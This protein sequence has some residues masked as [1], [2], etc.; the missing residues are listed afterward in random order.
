MDYY[1]LV[2][3]P[4][5]FDASKS[6][7]CDH[8]PC[9][10]FVW[11]FG[12]GSPKETTKG[13]MTQH[14]YA[15]PGVYPVE[16]EVTDKYGKTGKA[17]CTQ[18]IIDPKDPD[19]IG[20]P[21]AQLTSDPT[22]SKVGQVVYFDASKSHD[23]QKKP[24]EHYVFD[25]GDGTK[26]LHS[27]VPKVTHPYAKRGA[28]PVTV[29]VTDKYGQKAKAGLQ[30][31][32]ID[33][34]MQDPGDPYAHLK[35]TPSEA[36]TKEP[37]EFDG[38]KSMDCD[39]EPVKKYVFD[40]G[41]GSKPVT[42]FKP[43]VHH[44][45]AKGGTYPV[46][47][48]VTDKYG[49][50][51]EAMISQ[52]VK[53]P[54]NPTKKG[55]PS[56]ALKSTPPLADIDEPVTFDASDSHDYL[57]E[58]CELFVWD[59]G[60]GSPKKTSTTPIV[61]HPYK[62][63]GTYPVTVKVTDK[64]GQSAPAKI[65]QRVQAPPEYVTKDQAE[66][67]DD[68]YVT[69]SSTPTKA[70]INQPVTF[71]ASP[72]KDMD[73]E[74]LKKFIW[75]FGDG[76]P[77]KETPGP[78]VKHPYKESGTYPVKVIGVDKYGRKGDAKLNQ[79]VVDPKNPNEPL[80]PY[81]H[82]KSDPPI[83]E[84]KQPVKFDASKSHD[85]FN[86]PCVQFVW[87]FGDGSPKVTTPG[88][89]TTHP[90]ENP[91]T[92]P[93]KV[94]VTD[95]NGLSAQAGLNQK[96]IQK[97]P[98]E[99]DP[100][101]AV[102]STPPEAKPKEPVRFDA[103]KSHD[104]DG[105][106][107]KTFKWD[108][109]DG[110]P[111]VTTTTPITNHAY[112][113]PGT[114]PVKVT[115][116]DKYNRQGDA[117]LQQKVIDPKNPTKKGPPYA[118][119]K[120][121]PPEAAINQPVLFDA[122][123]SHDF[124]GE[125]CVKYVWDFGDGSPKKTTEEPEVTHPYKKAGVYPVT[126]EVTDKY[127]QKGKAGVN[128]RVRAP[129]PEDP[130]AAL[131]STP[132]EAKPKE[133]VKFD[134]SRSIDCDGDPCKQF[135][136]DFGDKSPPVIS[137]TPVVNH[138]YDEPGT[139][140]VTVTV[141]DKHGNRANASLQQKVIDPLDP[142]YANNNEPTKDPYVTVSSTPTKAK[143]NEPVTFDASPSHD[144]DKDPLKKFIWD[145][146]DGSP[147]KTTTGPITKHPYKK[148]GTYPVTVTGVDKYGRKGNAKLNQLVVDP[149]NP[150]K[151][152][153]PYAAVTSDPPEAK[154]DE[155]VK[156]DASKSHDFEKK[157]CVKFVWDFGDKSPKVTTKE[158]YT[159]HP[160]KAPGKYPV[161]VQ[162]T[163]KYN[164]TA[165]AGLDQRVVDPMGFYSVPSNEPLKDPTVTVSSTPS[166]AKV[167]EPVTFDASPSHDMDGEPL[168]K[169]IWDFGDGSPK[170]TT[171]EPIV[172]HPYKKPGSYPV[173]VTGIDKYGQ[174]GNAKLT[175]QVIDPKN[176]KKKLPPYAAITSDPP[177]SKVDEP[178]KF[179]A[180]K[181]H[182]FEKKPCKKFV[183]DFGDGSPKVTTTEPYTTHP[184]K[185][186]GKYPVTV[187]VT[188]RF[189]QKA[190]AGL[191]QRVV[192]P[193]EFYNIPSNDPT[194]DPYV[195]VSSTPPTAKPKEPVVFDASKSHDMDGDPC[196][197][198]TWDF[199]DGSPLVH[200]PK[201]VVTHA[202]DNPGSYP[203]KVTAYDKYNRKGDASLT[204]KVID[205]KNPKK[206][207]PP[208]AA[209]T[210]DPPVADIKEPV[211]FDASESK[212]FED[213]PCVK[214]VWDFGD[215]S[216]K[217]ITK[218]PTTKHP[219]EKAG[220]YPVT[221]E[222][223]DKHNQ[224]AKAGLTQKVAPGGARNE[225]KLP[226]ED[227][228]VAVSSTPPE[229]KVKEPVTFDASK[230]HDMD[231]DPLKKYLW[232]FGDG[233]PK[234]ETTGPV[235]KHAYDKPGTYP[236]TV[237]GTDKYNR[238]G[239]AKLSQV[240]KD[241]KGGPQPPYAAI[242]STPPDAQENE[243]VLFDASKSK[244]YQGNPVVSYEWD[245]GDG[246][247]KKTSKEPRIKHPYKKAG[248]YP[249][250][251][252]VTDKNGLKADA[253][254]D[255]RVV[256]KPVKNSKVKP[257]E[258]PF[259]TVSSTPTQAKV[260]EPVTFDASPSHDMDDDPLEKFIWD[261]GDG[262]P[263]KTTKEPIV[264]HPYKKP[265]TYPVT[266]TGI[267]KY[268]RKGD[269]KLN[270]LVIDPKNPK[271]VLPPY[272]ALESTPQDAEEKEPVT[273]DASKSHDF[274]KKPVVKYVWDFGDG[275]P[276][277]TTKTPL[278]K[279]PYEKAGTYPVTVTVTD[280]HNQ[281]A[282]ASINQRVVPPGSRN[283]ISHPTE[284]P[285]VT[286]S[287]TPT[288][289]KINQPVKFDA[290]PSH[291]MDGDPL[292]KFVWDFGDGSPKKTTTGPTTT[293]PYKKPGTYPVTVVGTD[294]YNRK[295][296]AKLNQQVIDPK[297]PKD[298]LP[299][300]AA[301]TS[302]PPTSKVGQ[303]VQF[304]ASKS[305]DG[306]KKP[307][308]KFVWDFGDGSPKQI[309]KGPKTKHP[310]EHEGTYPVSV[311]VT[312]KLGQE[313][314]AGLN[315][316]VI[317]EME[318]K[319]PMKGK[320][321][322]DNRRR[323]DPTPVIPSGGGDDYNEPPYAAVKSTPPE[324][325]P[326]QPVLCDASD[327]QD[328]QGNPCV[329][330]VWD[331]GDGSPKKT[332]TTP[333]TEHPYKKAGTYPI[334]VDVTD[335]FGNP[336]RAQCNQRVR[337]PEIE[338]PFAHVTSDPQYAKP[339]EPVKFDASKSHDMDGDPCK[340]FVWDYGDGSPLET[341]TEPVTNHAYD[342]PG[343]YPVT[344][345]VTDK[346]GR[347]GN[348]NLTQQVIDPRDPDKIYPPVA[349]LESHPHESVPKQPVNFDAS[350]SRDYKGE[351]CK[352][353]VWDFGDGSPKK[354]TKTPTTTHAY[355]KPGS[356]PVNVEVTDKYD[357]TARAGVNQRVREP[358][359][360]DPYVALNNEPPISKP[361]EPVTFDASKSVDMD[362]D[363]CKNYTFD[364]G[365]GSPVV[366]T[367][368]P[369]VKHAYDNPGS[370]PVTVTATDKYGRKGNAAVTQQVIDPK[371]PKKK[372]PPVA[373]VTSDPPDARPKQPVTFDASKSHDMDK[374]PCVKFVWD[375]GDGSPKKTTK[376]PVTKH[377]YAKP[378]VYPVT[379]QVTDKYNQ[380]ADAFLNQRVSDPGVSDVTLATGGICVVGFF[381]SI[382]C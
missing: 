11:D 17:Q 338:D 82:I 96:V 111:E 136:F 318:E 294:K 300:Y 55:P 87:D 236:V 168:E 54:F 230:S 161:K 16:V 190:D 324:S 23:Y 108:F 358:G 100:Y 2:N 49:K 330:F 174:P 316:R 102:S 176:P 271:K 298:P 153:P 242:E 334:T 378:G 215:G 369:V 331:F 231:N 227:P 234:V 188:D 172:K 317:D 208:Y 37:V 51:A 169:F 181:S 342:E 367:P 107:C 65:N 295:G 10:K 36:K 72:S 277:K 9:V 376:T 163:D 162:V 313:A 69:V 374:K 105:D 382:T 140:P 222:V 170:K 127:G 180:S 101:A 290:S 278:V 241:P 244:D 76:S 22:E 64:Y 264:K 276:K 106:P 61:Q 151:K 359:P 148:P 319:S 139:Y 327:S 291:D 53:D 335:K 129:K 297:N 194:E 149:K 70:K 254:L 320:T 203:V 352:K 25:F 343:S 253:G 80:P 89:T 167:N 211:D 287:S 368:K 302:D 179:D 309:T 299:P 221:V 214:F 285:Y 131:Q 128:Q 328:Y 205:P 332:T 177:E 306:E 112:D 114:Y 379:V 68:P 39:G 365:D 7:D 120:S 286:V 142:I 75:D 137:D 56:A 88:P 4:V 226:T 199:G 13:P 84:V 3:K 20:P 275:S 86:K 217:K 35:G 296:T 117:S 293:H 355:Q 262:S 238:K 34:D 341:T 361:K 121:T 46:T 375:F 337:E 283:L 301:I 321:Y 282:D 48:T 186:Q 268:G 152:L 261:F 240:V 123:D 62:E 272:A 356:Y 351:P 201:P 30:Q 249:V 21:Y 353:F 255:Q 348:A 377:P 200:T 260:N 94:V 146:G 372:M 66:K 225:A 135:V 209:V 103:S 303:P 243:P 73:G 24:V 67:I 373:K 310:Y 31:R 50:Q 40:F 28:Y 312:D 74:P 220:S 304:D 184:Y 263:K 119:L 307:C 207:M 267:D 265:G 63:A 213:K 235:T 251:V 178:V 347:K 198:Y 91:G 141:T 77:L 38:S 193:M 229:A 166:Q 269:A 132:P 125:P 257:T 145:F 219:Y 274:E 202:Y 279:H 289:A 78:I 350:K 218:T 5:D 97:G 357:Q 329:K 58:P 196:K 1:Q 340:K 19:K 325:V 233:S 154:V 216:P 130:Y 99:E 336:G 366:H 26:P 192:D 185:K 59:F 322:P 124:K 232:D 258:D 14:P 42:S 8:A 71:D 33:P 259:V 360:E 12:D 314:D 104:M 6:H 364:F 29:E 98:S 246:S 109:G 143:I 189:G 195:A 147:K 157:P 197:N 138:A 122:S 150:K 160:Y 250:T 47:L 115:V 284:D 237:V 159:T 311:T 32:V 95:K 281:T 90:Y 110:T 252:E 41:D 126:V 248:T 273:F 133:P 370:Y 27:K 206:I 345:T 270:Q 308:V 362:G 363:P 256:P 57:G 288:K 228:Y 326:G 315:Q 175:Q 45:Y 245:F 212:D 92:Y 173:K 292:K 346:Y 187:E 15:Y 371:N 171:T 116:T 380:T 43:I 93:V 81:A 183:W 158:P 79:L 156:F 305:H 204:Q 381:G 134:A 223:T 118:A 60:D 113:K 344:V 354:T 182:D 44:P 210:S 333:Q 339:K 164:Q 349:E 323:D 247:P 52:R 83:S 85:Q 280:K 239:H 224:T 18:R 144:M 155:P 191:D 266:V 165:D